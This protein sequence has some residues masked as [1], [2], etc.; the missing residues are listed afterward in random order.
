MTSKKEKTKIKGKSYT[1]QCLR[2]SPSLEEDK[3]LLEDIELDRRQK[4]S[5]MIQHKSLSGSQPFEPKDARIKLTINQ[6]ALKK[7]SQLLVRKQKQ[8]SMRSRNKISYLSQKHDLLI[9]DDSYVEDEAGVDQ[10]SAQSHIEDCLSAKFSLKIYCF[11][12]WKSLRLRHGDLV[13]FYGRF[14]FH[15][16]Q[17]CIVGLLGMD[18]V[19]NSMKY[20]ENL[21]DLE[22]N[23]WEAFSLRA[24]PDSDLNFLVLEPSQ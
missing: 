1:V 17:N 14:L 18:R 16:K 6:G 3:R 12:S 9:E 19:L 21:A 22:N 2:I 5:R 13:T 10:E 4:E 24:H 8:T 20:T 7:Y 23:S 11:N 15:R